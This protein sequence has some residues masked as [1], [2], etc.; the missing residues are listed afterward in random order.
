MITDKTNILLEKAGDN[1]PY[2]SL[3]Y[4]MLMIRMVEEKIVDLYPNQEMR[5]PVHL[6]IGQ[7]AVSVGVCENLTDGDIVFSNHRAHGHYLAKGGNLKSLIAEI[8][9]KVTGCSKGRGGSMHLLDLSVNFLGSTPI[10]GGTIPIAVGTALAS[11]MRSEDTIT[12]IF[13]GD[14]AV[15]EGVFHESLNFASLKHLPILF[16]CENNLYSVNTPLSDRQPTREIFTLAEGHDIDAYQEDGNDVLNVYELTRRAIE[17]IRAGNGPVFLEFLTYR[18]R[19]HCGP[20]HDTCLGYRSESE[21]KDW[22]G[23]CPVEKFEEKLLQ[24]NLLSTSII[25][26]MKTDIRNEIESAFSFAIKSPF[27]DESNLTQSVYSE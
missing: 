25:E 23:R 17:K 3:F 8:Y 5:C 18:F 4:K 15:E 2:S 24:N 7:E 9:G 19:E 10:V 21:L 12:V 16:V 26:D 14:G 11:K 1:V 13:F 27:P 6:C 22:M 20:N